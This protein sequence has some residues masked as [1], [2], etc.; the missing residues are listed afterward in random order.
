MHSILVA[1]HDRLVFEEYFYGFDRSKP[2]DTRSAAKTFA[3]VLLGTSPARAAGLTPDTRIYDVM[4]A[5]F[6]NPDP[7][8]LQITLANLMTHTSGLA[9]NDNDDA[10]PG[11]E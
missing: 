1:H 11:N 8:K 3:S 5:S 6:A 7:R 9:C 10:S 2:H 4:H